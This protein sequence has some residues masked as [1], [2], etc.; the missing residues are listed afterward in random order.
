M[1]RAPT[2]AAAGVADADADGDGDGIDVLV[3]GASAA[4]TGAASASATCS[5]VVRKETCSVRVS[6]TCRRPSLEPIT[7][8]D[9][10]GVTA[11]GTGEAS[12]DKPTAFDA[13]DAKPDSSPSN[14]PEIGTVQ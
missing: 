5:R 11:R 14:L 12:P 1:T 8:N 13:S 9:E 10:H 6:N 4:A 2:P 3:A 7:T